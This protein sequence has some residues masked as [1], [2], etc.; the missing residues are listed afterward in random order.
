[1]VYVYVMMGL[2]GRVWSGGMASVLAREIQKLPGVSCEVFKH[3]QWR[4]VVHAIQ[5]QPK[6]SRTVVIGHSMGAAAATYVTDEVKVD[7]VVLYDLAGQPPSPIGRNT[8]LCIDI[9]DTVPDMVPEWRARAVPG[10]EHKIKRWES[11]YGH[12]NQDDS[13]ELARRVVA[14]IELLKGR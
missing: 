11:R 8:G 4:T 10:H 3:S 2:G 13:V 5:R 9:Y 14:Q 12:T 6:G 1:M 7:L